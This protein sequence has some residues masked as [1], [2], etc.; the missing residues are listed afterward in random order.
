MQLPANDRGQRRAQAQGHANE[1]HD[2]CALRALKQIL[3][4]GT[5]DHHAGGAAR[6]LQNARKHQALDVRHA[7]GQNR[8]CQ[9]QREANE[10]DGPAT[11]SVRQGPVDQLQTA[12][13]HHKATEGQLN[14]RLLSRKNGPPLLHRRQANGHGQQAKRNLSQQIGHQPARWPLQK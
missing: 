2:P 1:G 5:P 9:A 12:I 11:V 3:H 14:L 13:G 7:S 8:T 4:H 6:A 10:Q